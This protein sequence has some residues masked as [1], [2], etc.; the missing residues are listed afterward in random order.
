MYIVK[1]NN[2]GI[3]TPWI[4]ITFFI[5]LYNDDWVIQGLDMSIRVY[6]TGHIQ[7]PVPLIEKSRASCSGGRFS[8]SFIPQAIIIT[9]LNTL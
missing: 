3:L 2:L 6:A 8:P 1:L 4:R 5:P 7:N 9:G